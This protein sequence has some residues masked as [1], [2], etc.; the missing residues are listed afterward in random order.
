M[1][2]LGGDA[3]AEV[4]GSWDIGKVTRVTPA[5]HGHSNRTLLIETNRGRF[6]LRAY[7]HS[8]RSRIDWEHYVIDHLS[9]AGIPAVRAIHTRIGG[10]ML[11]RE[12]RSYS[13]F[14]HAPGAQIAR[15][16]LNDHTI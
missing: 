5:P 8:D 14:P 12:Q 10:P 2:E 4:V 7:S 1:Q 13:L 15:A 3:L 9:P 6:A 11:E 16:A